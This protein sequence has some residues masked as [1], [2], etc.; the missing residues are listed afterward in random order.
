MNR[1]FDLLPNIGGNAFLK[2]LPYLFDSRKR[3]QTVEWKPRI[4]VFSMSLEGS[5]A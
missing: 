2:C 5:K 4:T 1:F 3:D